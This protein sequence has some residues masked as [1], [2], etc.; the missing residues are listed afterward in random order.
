[1]GSSKAPSETLGGH[2]TTSGS[3]VAPFHIV[4]TLLHDREAILK[5]SRE[6]VSLRADDRLDQDSELMAFRFGMKRLIK[7]EGLNPAM[8][9]ALL[10]LPDLRLATTR[11]YRPEGPVRSNDVTLFAS[12]DPGVADEALAHEQGERRSGS[13]REAT[14][15]WFGEQLGYPECCVARFRHAATQDDDA[16]LARLFERDVWNR[17]PQNANFLVPTVSPVTHYPCSARCAAS[18]ALGDRYMDELAATAPELYDETRL[19][20]AAPMLLFDRFRLVL[21]LG[22]RID[23]DVVRYDRA[24]I[25]WNKTAAH[26]FRDDPRSRLFYLR[27]APL[28]VASNCIEIARDG[29]LLSRDD[30]L[31]ASII[32]DGT[33][34][35]LIEPEPA[36]PAITR[37][38]VET[39]PSP[40]LEAAPEASLEA[41]ADAAVEAAIEAATEASLETTEAAVEEAAGASLEATEAALRAA[42]GPKPPT[43]EDT[44]S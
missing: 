13:H 1:M 2:S 24:W 34:P 44:P 38:S 14:M 8:E 11:L 9:D 21:L 20:T 22:A 28:F 32:L 33:L 43:P 42:L 41:A 29:L 39:G 6:V 31:I 7:R 25:P 15:T 10:S 16:M 17:L 27:V 26:A 12:M 19:L 4:Q 23:D 40:I 35:Y 37:P 5:A 30:T 18:V 36:P 3:E